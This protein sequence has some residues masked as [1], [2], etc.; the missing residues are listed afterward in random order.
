MA[1]QA[2]RAAAAAGSYRS[3]FAPKYTVPLKFGGLTLTQGMRF[4]P[5]A[6]TFGVAAGIFGVFFLGDVPR[7][8]EDILLNIPVIGSYWEKRIAPED[9]PF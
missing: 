3:P 7:I 8:R 4:M 1:S 5:I 2:P 9:N 6:T